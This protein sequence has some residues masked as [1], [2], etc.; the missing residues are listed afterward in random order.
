MIRGFISR[1]SSCL[2]NG[3]HHY[4][5]KKVLFLLFPSHCLLK[6]QFGLS[7][8]HGYNLQNQEILMKPQEIGQEMDNPESDS[9]GLF[10][11]FPGNVQVHYGSQRERELVAMSENWE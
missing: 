1:S 4:A 2:R 10:C 9:D 3:S 7:S 11:I 6:I 5:R 8:F